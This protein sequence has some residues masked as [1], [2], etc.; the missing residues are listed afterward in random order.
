MAL[1]AW[2]NGYKTMAMMVSSLL[3]PRVKRLC[4]PTP[5]VSAIDMVIEVSRLSRPVT[6]E[7][8]NALLADAA[9]AAVSYPVFWDDLERLRH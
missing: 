1:V 3:A 7:A 4:L 5:N 9:A 8:V 6:V 2:P